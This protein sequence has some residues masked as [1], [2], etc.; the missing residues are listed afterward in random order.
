MQHPLLRVM[1]FQLQAVVLKAFY[2]PQREALHS[3]KKT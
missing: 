3:E 2:G 1:F